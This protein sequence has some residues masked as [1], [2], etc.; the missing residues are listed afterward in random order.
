MKYVQI[1]CK[2]VVGYFR[3]IILT[4]DWMYN[5]VYLVYGELNIF[6]HRSYTQR[7]LERVY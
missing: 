1:H 6:R 4:M 7:R 3:T 5:L 2:R